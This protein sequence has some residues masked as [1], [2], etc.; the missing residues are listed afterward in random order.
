[1][2]RQLSILLFSL[3][4]GSAIA[5]DTPVDFVKDVRPILQQRCYSC[6]AEQKQKSG[7][8][9]DIKASA[10]DGGDGYGAAIVAGDVDG[11]PLIELVTSD[12]E[13]MRMPPGADGLPAAEID[14]LTRW[15]QQGAVWPDGVDLAQ[16]EDRTD[17]WSFKPLSFPPKESATGQTTDDGGPRPAGADRI[18]AFIREKL[19]ANDLALSAPAPRRDW[20]RRVYFDLIGLPPTP[21]QVAAFEQDQSDDAH[22]RVVDQLLAS[23]HY[24]ERWGQHWLDVVRY[25]DTHGF[26]VNTTRPNA[27]PYRDYVIEA[28][29]NDT[30]YDQ[31][32]HE[33]L[34]G[35]SLQKDAAT[36]FLVTAAAL[37]P[38]QIGKDD[39]S[40]RLA[41][42]DELAE[43]VINTS[44]AF[45]GLSVGCARCHDHKFDA[46]SHE[47]YFAMQAFFSGVKYGERPIASVEN[48]ERTAEAEKLET[49]LREIDT[50]LQQ[51]ID[52]ANLAETNP[53]LNRL[54]F[55]AMDARFVRFTI[56]DCNRHPSLGLIEPCV[57]EFEIIA[58]DPVETNVALASLGT[59]VTASG[60]RTSDKHRLEHVNDGQ[61]GNSR[62]WMSDTAGRG[63]LLFELAEPTS[64]QRVDWSRDRQ[65]K[66][67]DRLPTMFTLEAGPSLDAMQHLAGLTD[68]QVK[69]SLTLREEKEAIEQKLAQL[70]SRPMVFAG[71]FSK[72]VPTPFLRR[73]DPEQPGEPVPPAVLS[74]LGDIQLDEET[75]DQERRIALADWIASPDNPLT[76][77]VMVNRVWQWHFGTGLVAT[78]SD[79]GRSGERPSHPLLL[80]WL[81]SEF[82]R[83]GWSVKHLHR[84]IVLSTTY[85][86]SNQIDPHSQGI[87][88][89]VRLLWRFPSRRLEAEA[90]RD[91]MLA[92]NG[93]LN[94]TTGGPG[95]DLFKSRGGL[96][97]FPPIESFS[98][99]GLRR[100]VYAHK[101]RMEPE[102]VFGAF[103]CPDAGQS[104]ARRQQSTT[105]IQ[106][107][108]LFNSVFTIE[109]SDALASRAETEM[110]PDVKDQIRFIYRL[111]LA[112]EPEADELETAESLVI[113]HG[114]PTLCRAIYNS[115]EFLFIP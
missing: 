52:L 111:A 78:P 9:L 7:F 66:L 54:P 73:G 79:L 46:V 93:R 29:N 19:E 109:Q 96:S 63:W 84:L 50:E 59:K 43:I 64:I 27:W 112:R 101:I 49:R 38:G 32:I 100:M 55:A 39:A 15:V 6:H 1:M 91:S 72:P 70:N 115:N 76:A 18:D 42:Q 10:F 23:Q 2:N 37:L 89:D 113:Q 108:N 24:G 25:A 67:G 35:D 11:S 71:V 83:S 103:D 57:D 75:P 80:D 62:S 4:Y 41:R 45:L 12:D 69:R 95:F 36:G 87:D 21:A 65:Q 81:A 61:Y 82:I 94:G 51:Q 30:P 5:A 88:A 40:K 53:Q 22:R 85:G 56:H 104:T 31:F 26:E 17:H 68:E 8:R 92:V 47:D 110:G 28:F 58:A 14:I 107:L 102:S 34:H 74:A 90:I 86:Q 114:L 77:R 16:L 33:Q 48:D 60:S 106:A 13:D 105:P 98:N 99:K 44:D 20:I 97:G 3:F